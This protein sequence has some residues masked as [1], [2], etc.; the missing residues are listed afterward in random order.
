MTPTATRTRIPEPRSADW[1]LRP[2][3][4]GDRGVATV[5]ADISDEL[6]DGMVDERDLNE[7]IQRRTGGNALIIG[8]MVDEALRARR[9][10]GTHV[11]TVRVPRYRALNG[12]RDRIGPVDLIDRD[13]AEAAARA[14][15]SGIAQLRRAA[16]QAG[17]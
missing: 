6:L 15:R 12:R 3:G 11:R 5:E 16:K 10:S 8:C 1:Y 13:S 4:V 14:V 7:E 17:R 2:I 9:A